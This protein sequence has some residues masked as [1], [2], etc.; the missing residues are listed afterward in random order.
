M[1]AHFRLG[2]IHLVSSPLDQIRGGDDNGKVSLSKNAVGREL[3]AKNDAGG[4]AAGC[5]RIFL[6]G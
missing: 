4:E 5:E 6:L 2:D 1:S 3:I